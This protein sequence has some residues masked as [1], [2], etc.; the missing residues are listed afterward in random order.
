ML[1]NLKKSL[2]NERKIERRSYVTDRERER[3]SK[4]F[5]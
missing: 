3:R 4:F 1:K 5:V 2:G